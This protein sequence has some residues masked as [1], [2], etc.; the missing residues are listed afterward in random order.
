MQLKAESR[1]SE[2]EFKLGALR[3]RRYQPTIIAHI[4]LKITACSLV[5]QELPESEA[6]KDN[7]T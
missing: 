7:Q 2:A 3:Y 1:E 6:T 5:Y 4:S